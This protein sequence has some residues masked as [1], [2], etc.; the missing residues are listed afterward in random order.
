[1]K[2]AKAQDEEPKGRPFGSVE[3]LNSGKWR[4]RYV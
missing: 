3:Q 1:M 2:R 4:A